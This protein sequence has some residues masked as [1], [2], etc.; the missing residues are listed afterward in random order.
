MIW[1]V[2]YR[3]ERGERNVIEIEA[4]DRNALF[5]ELRRRGISAISVAEGKPRRKIRMD[6]AVYSGRTSRSS[7]VLY[8]GIVGIIVIAASIGVWLYLSS[9]K[10]RPPTPRATTKTA[11]STAQKASASQRSKPTAQFVPF[12]RVEAVSNPNARH[13]KGVEVV[14][15]SATT[16]SID[17]AIVERLKLADGRTV[18]VVTLPKPLFENPSDQ[19]I[20]M[21]LSSQPGQSV[22]PMPV[23]A[24]VEQAFLDSLLS[25]IK[26]NED[27][28]DNVKEIKANVIEARAYIADEVKAGKSVR[29]V[30]EAYQR[31]MNDIADRH[32]MAVQEMQK[33]K[34]EYGIEAAREF[35]VRV[36][37]AF[38]ARGV[39]EINV[40]GDNE[41]HR[42]GIK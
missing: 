32:L 33:I 7:R 39:P 40:P 27:D 20:A 19:L 9:G 6:K 4:A 41:H 12:N 37:E 10:T 8:G 26:I 13:Y 42:S 18:K 36:N 29:E 30:L 25:P 2:T 35:A 1:T 23:D 22:A 21:A 16:N 34:A 15:S 31:Q 11:V 24:N 3:D 14:A 28:P 5:D 38:C 17:G